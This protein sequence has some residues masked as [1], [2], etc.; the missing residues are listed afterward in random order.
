MLNHYERIQNA[1]DFIEDNLSSP[2]NLTEVSKK[3]FSSLSYMHRVFYF[4]TGFT[5]KEYIRRRRL[6]KAA[7]AL[8]CTKKAITDIA[9]EACFETPESFSRA[10]KK[11]YGSSPRD[12]RQKNQEQTLFERLNILNTYAKQP[13]P[14]LDF[15]LSSELVLYKETTV[16][17]FQTHTTIENA[18]Q[19]IDI[20]NFADEVLASGKLAQYFDLSSSPIFGVYTNMT[21]ESDFDYTIGALEKNCTT[22][23]EKLVTHT[24]PSSSYARFT[25]DRMD[26]IKE[27][28]HYIY[29]YWFPNNNE[30]RTEGF[31]F[32]I[33]KENSVDIYI[34]MNKSAL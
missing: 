14:A 23:S 21:D 6:S 3:A 5:L 20:C 9:L 2:I 29:G 19:T 13:K 1:L 30:Y 4:M 28:W 17:G 33:Y 34:P 22:P 7:Y 26:R 31:D 27:A 16:Q 8:H 24:L 12:F 11:H 10:F 32:E 18:Q 25:L 15:S